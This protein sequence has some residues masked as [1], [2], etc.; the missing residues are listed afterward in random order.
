VLALKKSKKNNHKKNKIME[1][2]ITSI[3]IHINTPLLASWNATIP[4]LYISEANVKLR[5]TEE[6][7]YT[8]KRSK[9]PTLQDLGGDVPAAKKGKCTT[10][11][12]QTLSHLL[13]LT[14]PFRCAR[15]RSP[16]T[17]IIIHISKPQ[18]TRPTQLE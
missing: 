1:N 14:K 6:R 7:N 11:L 9:L 10:R 16:L 5:T 17:N 4:R 15:C 2:I 8:K 3:F 18:E 12:L 13:P